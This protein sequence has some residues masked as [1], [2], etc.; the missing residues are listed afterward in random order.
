MFL[1]YFYFDFLKMR[2]YGLGTK[3]TLVRKQNY[4]LGKGKQANV[5]R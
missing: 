5:F 3:T 4:F 1:F 2:C